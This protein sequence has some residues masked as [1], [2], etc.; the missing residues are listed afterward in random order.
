MWRGDPENMTLPAPMPSILAAPRPLHPT[1]LVTPLATPLA[2]PRPS[3]WAVLP[4][5]P[6]TMP[7]LNIT[8]PLV[9]ATMPPPMSLARPVAP[10]PNE[11]MESERDRQRS[12]SLLRRRAFEE[13]SRLHEDR[14][15]VIH[16]ELQAARA[17][18]SSL[19]NK[20]TDEQERAQ[21][22]AGTL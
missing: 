11:V 8:G 21:V 22:R 3:A 7:S 17:E 6:A 14:E 18:L 20:L 9:S 15:S 2:T 16:H 13:S 1:P 10:T 4:L 12:I 19:R 5:P